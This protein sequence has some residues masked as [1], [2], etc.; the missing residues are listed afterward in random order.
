MVRGRVRSGV[1][2]RSEPDLVGSESGQSRFVVTEAIM[3]K[4]VVMSGQI[5]SDLVF[6]A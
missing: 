2:V 3:V 5:A 6:M 1:W 4:D